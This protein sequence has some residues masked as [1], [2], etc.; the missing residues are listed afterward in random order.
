MTSYLILSCFIYSVTSYYTAENVIKQNSPSYWLLP[1]NFLLRTKF[2]SYSFPFFNHFCLFLPYYSF[3]FCAYVVSN[4]NIKFPR[5]S[6]TFSSLRSPHSFVHSRLITPYY[7]FA[8]PPFHS[9]LFYSFTFF[10]SN[11]SL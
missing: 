10:F 5:L 4:S 6:P 8:P 2:A 3:L 1:L 7:A 9:I 11:I